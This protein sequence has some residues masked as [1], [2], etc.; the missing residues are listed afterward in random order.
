LQKC[1]IAPVHLKPLW[2]ALAL[3][4]AV[5]SHNVDYVKFFKVFGK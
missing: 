5:Y 1:L 4:R 2:C 3:V